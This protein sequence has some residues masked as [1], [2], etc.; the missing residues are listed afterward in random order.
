MKLAWASH[1]KA[2]GFQDGTFQ[3]EKVEAIGLLSQDLE[4]DTALFL[5][6]FIGQANNRPA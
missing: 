6:Y 3:E 4:Y 5:S 2:A 1:S